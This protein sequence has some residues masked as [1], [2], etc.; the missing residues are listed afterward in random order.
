MAR[1]IR[2][3]SAKQRSDSTSARNCARAPGSS[4]EIQPRTSASATSSSSSTTAPAASHRSAAPTQAMTAPMRS[5][6]SSSEHDPSS[7]GP[8]GRSAS[9]SS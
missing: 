9:I 3:R 1:T 4:P 6:S 2:A 7:D 8:V 5:A